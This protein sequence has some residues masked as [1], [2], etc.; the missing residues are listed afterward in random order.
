MEKAMSIDTAT[1][2]SLD[3][4][5]SSSQLDDATWAQHDPTVEQSYP[6]QW[7]IAVERKIVAH[8]TDP[9]Q[10]RH[11]AA[12]LTGRTPDELIVCGIPRPEDWLIDV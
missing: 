12:R 2:A 3:S 9:D 7:V 11:E 4:G 10:V 6:G 5:F 8:G 1:P